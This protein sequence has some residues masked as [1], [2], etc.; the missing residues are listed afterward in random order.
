[1]NKHTDKPQMTPQ[2]HEIIA[3]FNATASLEETANR[4]GVRTVEV[5]ET[6]RKY[7]KMLEASPQRR[8]HT[9]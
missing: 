9:D 1:M 7:Q 8:I 6:L 2:E 4:C 3:T 5:T